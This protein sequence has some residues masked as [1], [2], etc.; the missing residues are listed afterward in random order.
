M[1]VRAELA[2]PCRS[3]TAKPPTARQRRFGDLLGPAAWR[4][5]RADHAPRQ[6]K[7]LLVRDVR[8][9]FDL[10][11]GQL[12]PCQA[13]FDEAGLV[14]D[15]LAVY[16]DRDMLTAS[17]SFVAHP[18]TMPDSADKLIVFDTHDRQ[19]TALPHPRVLHN[20]LSGFFSIAISQ[21]EVGHLSHSRDFP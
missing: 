21:D 2:F 1:T 11:Q 9:V 8:W 12:G 7:R 3:A 10:V 18:T 5:G 14:L 15:L 19:Q 4:V 17:E 16:L 20:G 13:A 6:A